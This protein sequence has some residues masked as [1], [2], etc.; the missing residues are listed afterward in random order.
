MAV[1]KEIVDELFKLIWFPKNDRWK[2]SR[3]FNFCTKV[4]CILL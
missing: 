2:S 4:Q 3:F 1:A